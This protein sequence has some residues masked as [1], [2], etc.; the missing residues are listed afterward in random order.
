MV[1][2]TKMVCVN[3]FLP[4]KPRGPDIAPPNNILL[5]TGLP[6]GVTEMG[7]AMIFSTYT[8]FRE[9]KMV[10]GRPDVAF[11]EYTSDHLAGEAKRGLQG[12]PLSDTHALQIAFA[13]K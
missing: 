2:Q 3:F 5:L 1:C 8:G 4:G 11:V 6:E 10:P 9:V 7:L 13:R 12:T